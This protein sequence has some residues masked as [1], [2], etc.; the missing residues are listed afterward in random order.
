[1]EESL[2]LKSSRPALAS[3]T[4]LQQKEKPR[5]ISFAK[6]LTDPGIAVLR[7]TSKIVWLPDDSSVF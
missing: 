5:I 3:K 2:Q 1:M 6:L 4:L 7:T